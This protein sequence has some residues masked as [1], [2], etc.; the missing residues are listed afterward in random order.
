M[1]VV[2][3]CLKSALEK[4]CFSEVWQSQQ[5]S[6]AGWL[7]LSVKQDYKISLFKNGCMM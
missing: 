2:R 1:Q 7:Y 4:L 6:D 3:L 5:F